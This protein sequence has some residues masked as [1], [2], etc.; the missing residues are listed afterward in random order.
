MRP[1]MALEA[2]TVR[3]QET[4]TDEREDAE[5]I[6]DDR[7]NRRA[8]SAPSARVTGDEISRVEHSGHRC[9]D[10]LW[11]PMPPLMPSRSRPH[12]AGRQADRDERAPDPHGA[13]AHEIERFERRQT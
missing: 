12:D 5:R 10:D 2:M 13:R 9:G 8:A 6:T 11:L 3:R 4:A 7:D 1:V